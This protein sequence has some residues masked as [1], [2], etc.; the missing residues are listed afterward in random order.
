MPE[1]PC[2][3]VTVTYTGQARMTF[4]SVVG[5]NSLSVYADTTVSPGDFVGGGLRPLS[6]C[7]DD[8]SFVQSPSPLPD[9]NLDGTVDLFDLAAGDVLR[10]E[11]ANTF[12]NSGPAPACGSAA[13]NWGWTC[14]DDTYEHPH[15]TDRGC[16]GNNSANNLAD[17]LL[18]GY[19]GEVDLGSAA[20]PSD[21]E[22]QEDGDPVSGDCEMTPGSPSSNAIRTAL[23]WLIDQQLEFPILGMTSYCCSGENGEVVPAAFIGV[24]M[25]AY[26]TSGSSAGIRVYPGENA[27]GTLEWI[28]FVVANV[29][30]DGSS[31][32]ATDGTLDR[33]PPVICGVDHQPGSVDYCER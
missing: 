27:N 17:M 23:R 32:L 1:G 24:R 12:R 11:V 25:T 15:D 10:L 6:I 19:G 9:R 22:C 20:D 16:D 2:G 8:P 14:F 21:H 18:A 33:T 13:G 3:K 4:A 31:A 30:E 7:M 5:F 28:E 29:F 26:A